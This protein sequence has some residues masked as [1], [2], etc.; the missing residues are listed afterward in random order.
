[1]KK[2]VVGTREMVPQLRTLAALPKDPCW[3]LAPTL[4]SLQLPVTPNPRDSAPSSGFFRHWHTC[5]CLCLHMYIN[6][7]FLT[8]QIYNCLES[9][10]V[11]RF[12]EQCLFISLLMPC[13]SNLEGQ[14][15]INKSQRWLR[16]QDNSRAPPK[17]TQVLHPLA[18][19]R[20]HQ[21]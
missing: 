1:M 10:I 18:A 17:H 7:F 21:P 11:D 9:G 19:P 4:G 15:T 8:S 5:A 12:R 14:K 6:L 16:H 20:P 3:F 13:S 2:L